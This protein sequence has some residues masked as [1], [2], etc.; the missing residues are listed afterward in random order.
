M[1]PLLS[2]LVCALAAVARAAPEDC[3]LPKERGSCS[4][5]A[6]RYYYDTE[7][8]GCLRFWYG[9]CDGNGNR[10]ATE[11]ECERSCVSPAGDDLCR[12]PAVRGACKR[13][14][15]R[16][17]SD[18]SS[19][20]CRQFMYSGCL[21]NDN[22]F[23]SES[24]CQQRCGRVSPGPVFP[25]GTGISG[26][27]PTTTAAPGPADCLLPDRAAGECS[28]YVIKYSYVAARQQC[29]PFYYGGCGGNGNRFDTAEACQ[30]ACMKPPT[31]RP[32]YYLQ[33][34]QR[35]PP[36]PR[37]PDVYDGR[38][39]RPS[40]GRDTRPSY[41]RDERPSYGRE[42]RPSY[43]RD[44][45]PSYGREER[46]PY[47][48]EE[49]PPYGREEQPSY[50]RRDR[51]SYGPEERPRPA[52]PEPDS[53]DTSAP[54]IDICYL[55]AV[56]G[57]CRAYQPS[58]Y[59]NA[60]GG[61][62]ERF[63]YGGCG[64][65]QNRFSTL[66]ECEERCDREEDRPEPT[67]TPRRPYQ[68]ETEA[69]YVPY[70]PVTETPYVPYRPE[71]EAP[72]VPFQR[73]TQAPAEPEPEI[74][75]APAPAGDIC[76][77]PAVPG[78]CRAYNPSYYF[79]AGPQRCERFIYGGCGGNENRFSTLAECE[80]RCGG[81]GAVRT[82]EVQPSEAPPPPETESP[83]TEA[84]DVIIALPTA[85]AL[86]ACQL[87]PNAG[88]CDQRLQRYYFNGPLNSCFTFTYGG[89]GGNANRFES[90][91][92]CRARCLPGEPEVTFAPFDFGG[93]GVGGIGG[94][95]A[96][97]ETTTLADDDYPTYDYDDYEGLTGDS[98]DTAATP[99]PDYYDAY[100]DDDEY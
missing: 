82:A 9:G 63:I 1:T 97:A 54:G 73:A 23:D 89:C 20:G 26:G 87:A 51:P 16:W 17:F 86:D 8:G 15:T 78:R 36:A 27:V 83:E 21:G 50:D 22:R 29:A 37:Q 76:S 48:R 30:A 24:A 47:G 43:G 33:P 62:C 66:A 71:T 75:D 77:L 42:E 6:V 44:E 52:E 94:A 79:N 4:Q 57:D 88:P 38:D 72:Y 65:N 92:E 68:P 74:T 40:Y 99:P 96:Q 60:A 98:I 14:K 49:R 41:G 61:R 59:F 3:G 12:L 7:Y 39:T 19:R 58:Y 93:V 95:E 32:P 91:A 67:E 45:R 56:P 55:P 46:P 90:V 69:P 64:G 81:G 13:T 35:T 53:R 5:F 100:Y 70:R 80:N 31:T 28:Q 84:P 18:P 11:S 2:V 85:A 10:F 25:G 34:R